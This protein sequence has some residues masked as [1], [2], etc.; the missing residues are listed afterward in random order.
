M[1][2]HKN[3]LKPNDSVAKPGKEAR[4]PNFNAT[5]LLIE[6]HNNLWLSFNF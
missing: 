6:Q 1:H 5:S 3:L 4:S 2:I